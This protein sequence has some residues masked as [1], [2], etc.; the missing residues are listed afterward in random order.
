MAVISTLPNDAMAKEQ[1][2]PKLMKVKDTGLIVLFSSRKM[3]QV[4]FADK[5]WPIG[6]TS[7]N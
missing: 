2:Y 7:N 3:G 1:D 4:V 6:E 5:N